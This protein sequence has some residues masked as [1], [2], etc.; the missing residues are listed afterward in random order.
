MASIRTRVTLNTFPV[1]IFVTFGKIQA[2]PL[3]SQEQVST[4]LLVV[5]PG[6]P[7]N[8]PVH[9]GPSGNFLC[10]AKF[11]LKVIRIYGNLCNQ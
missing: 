7:E 11:V 5:D 8:E 2:T 4:P 1:S 9:G 3:E 10:C 6:N